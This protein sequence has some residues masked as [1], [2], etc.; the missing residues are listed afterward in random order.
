MGDGT[1]FIEQFKLFDDDVLSKLNDLCLFKL[2]EDMFL[3]KVFG[4]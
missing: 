2:L 4:C 3:E 1:E